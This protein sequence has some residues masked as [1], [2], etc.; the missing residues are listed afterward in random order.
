MC[1]ICDEC[2]NCK[3]MKKSINGVS[4][5]VS[6]SFCNKNN[7]SF[8]SEDEIDC[9]DFE[10]YEPDEFLYPDDNGDYYYDMMRDAIYD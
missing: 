4:V 6:G 2:S 5:N 3:V 9:K 10:L 1:T 7:A 8:N